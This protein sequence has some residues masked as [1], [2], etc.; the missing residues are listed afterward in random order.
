MPGR[1][2]LMGEVHPGVPTTAPL[3]VD[4]DHY[5]RGGWCAR[6]GRTKRD[7]VNGMVLEAVRSCGL[8]RNGSTFTSWLFGSCGVGGRHFA[9]KERQRGGRRPRRRILRWILSSGER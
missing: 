1:P 4:C 8:E 6:V 7:P 9:T 5:R 3:C 2:P